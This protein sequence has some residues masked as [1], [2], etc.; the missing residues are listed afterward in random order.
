[1]L[2]LQSTIIAIVRILFD[3]KHCMLLKLQRN[4]SLIDI[5]DELD[6]NEAIIYGSDT[7]Y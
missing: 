3:K 1:M 5:K 2:R 6:E 7:P 4:R